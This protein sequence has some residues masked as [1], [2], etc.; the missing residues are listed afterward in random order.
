M[1]HVHSAFQ[2]RQ[3][4]IDLP[5]K[6]CSIDE[7]KMDLLE[8]GSRASKDMIHEIENFGLGIVSSFKICTGYRRVSRG[9]LPVRRGYDKGAVLDFGHG[10]S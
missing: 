10:N 8:R 6:G 1:L 2:S 3:G 5:G 9:I 4:E 7:W